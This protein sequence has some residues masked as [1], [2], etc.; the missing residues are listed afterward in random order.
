MKVASEK[1]LLK[2]LFHGLSYVGG[3][4][5]VISF[6]GNTFL[7]S[8]KKHHA[9]CKSQ[10]VSNTSVLG[11]RWV[12]LFYYRCFYV[13]S[14]ATHL[15]SQSDDEYRYRVAEVE[16]LQDIYPPEGTAEREDVSFSSHIVPEGYI[17]QQVSCINC[18]YKTSANVLI[19]QLLRCIIS[20]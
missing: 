15:L 5:M 19:V 18:D 12:S 6:Y 13:I 10:A 7:S 3:E 4:I 9:G 17:F 16:W 1:A 11:S 14:L 20:G 8:L 2:Y